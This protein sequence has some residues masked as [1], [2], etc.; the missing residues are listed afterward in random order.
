MENKQK[1]HYSWVIGIPEGKQHIVFGLFRE[2]RG[3]NITLAPAVRISNA[4]KFKLIRFK[5]YV[6]DQSHYNVFWVRK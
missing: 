4:G 2:K 5:Q 1:T 3:N 6:I